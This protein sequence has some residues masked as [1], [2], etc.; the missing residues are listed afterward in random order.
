MKIFNLKFSYLFLCL[1]LLA[2]APPKTSGTIF[3]LRMQREQL[4]K[5][6]AKCQQLLLITVFIT[7]ITNSVYCVKSSSIVDRP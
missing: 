7:Y 6:L 3:F 1:I 5:S 4:K 2:A